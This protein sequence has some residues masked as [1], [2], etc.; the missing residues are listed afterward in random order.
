[1]PDMR[2]DYFIPAGFIKKRFD[3]NPQN[4][5]ADG[6]FSLSKFLKKMLDRYKIAYEDDCCNVDTPTDERTALPV[7]YNGVEAQ[8][9]FYNPETDAWEAVA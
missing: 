6:L 7:R 5:E 2:P 9:E 8:L 3:R 1:M 4:D